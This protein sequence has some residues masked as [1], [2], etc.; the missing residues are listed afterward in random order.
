MTKQVSEQRLLT[1]LNDF[2]GAAKEARDI[3]DEAYAQECEDTA[4]IIREVLQHR[5]QAGMESEPVAVPDEREAF[6]AFMEEKFKDSID[7]KRVLNGD[8]GYFAWDMIV[9]WIVWQGRATMLK[10]DGTLINEGTKPLI[11][12]EHRQL[13]DLVMMVKMLCRTVKKYNATSQQ[14]KDYME[15]LQREGLISATDCLR[16]V[17][18]DPE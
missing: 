17:A 12:D 11:A 16:V 2:D 3:E 15:Y 5:Q 8:Q 1:L 14:A 18:K 4:S 13:R 6:E 9:A 7:R 10:A